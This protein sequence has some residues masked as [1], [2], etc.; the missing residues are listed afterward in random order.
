VDGAATASLANAR[1]RSAVAEHYAFVWRSLRRLGV[2]EESADD[3]AQRVFCVYAQRLGDVA[4]EKD[5]TFLFGVAMRVA[6]TSRRTIVRRGEVHDD[7]AL[8]AIPSDRKSAE[9]IVEAHP[10]A[11]ALV[12]GVP[13]PG[14][15]PRPESLPGPSE[16]DLV[17]QARTELATGS[18]AKALASLDARDAAYPHGGLVEDG[19]VV[20]IEA[21]SRTDP[22]AAIVA[23]RRFLRRYPDSA[24][25]DRVSAIAAATGRR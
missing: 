19:A 1:V 14:A 20:R 25:A 24:Y 15:P 16:L 12:A 4:P 11:S 2:P 22:P 3:G 23:A 6:Q 9:E 5:K 18:A 13:P 17:R 10:A 7:D 21:L 8:E